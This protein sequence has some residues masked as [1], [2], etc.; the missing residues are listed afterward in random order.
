MHSPV[1][2]PAEMEDMLALTL[3]F[4]FLCL[5]RQQAT[6]E[7]FNVFVAFWLSAAYM[8]TPCVYDGEPLIDDDPVNMVFNKGA[9]EWAR[10]WILFYIAYLMVD[11]CSE[12]NTITTEFAV[13]HAVAV[14]AYAAN[15]NTPFGAAILYNIFLLEPSSVLVNLRFAIRSDHYVYPQML[16]TAIDV[17]G[18]PVY[19]YLR[20]VEFPH[21]VY[22]FFFEVLPT[23]EHDLRPT[24]IGLLLGQVSL[25]VSFLL[26][27]YWSWQI[28]RKMTTKL[29]LLGE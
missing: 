16:K 20:C 4:L 17:L 28:L 23:L 25:A 7:W 26:N 6:K 21:R 3:N 15:C 12:L 8:Y 13:H 9:V 10:G 24:P 29:G 27:F 2:A 18:S 11:T 1:F 22:R 5:L 14:V 19:L